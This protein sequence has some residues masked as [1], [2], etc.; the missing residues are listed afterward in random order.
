MNTVAEI[1]TLPRLLGACAILQ[2]ISAQ[3]SDILSLGSA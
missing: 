1:E 3:S 2:M